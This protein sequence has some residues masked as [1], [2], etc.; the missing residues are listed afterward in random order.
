MTAGSGRIPSLDGLRAV[1]ISLVLY[2]HLEGGHGF[3]SLHLTRWFGDVA[4]LGVTVFFVI[5]GFLIT[6]LLMSERERTSTISLKNFYLRRTLRIFPAFYAFILALVLADAIG[7]ID[8]SGRDL[9][10]AVTYTVNYDVD[11]SWNIGHL[12]SLSIE[13]QFYLL[14]PCVFLMLRERRALIA[15]VLAFAAGPLVRLAMR[16]AFPA[17][18]PWRDLEIFPAMADSI[19]IGCVLALLRPW[20]LEQAWYLRLSGSA[21]LALVLVPL[22]LVINSRLGYSLVDLVGSPILLVSVAL[23]IEASTRRAESIAGRFLNFP[24]VVFLGVLSYSL[25]LWQQPFL[26]RHLDTAPTTFPLNLALAFGCALLS[27]FLI[28]RPLVGVR[29]RLERS[30]V[31]PPSASEAATR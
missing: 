4:H 6:S 26:N 22:I 28:E 13:E 12:W 16:L 17:G 1:S 10:F 7:W 21:W 11:R 9:A 24:P 19:A 23:L 8:L 14:W 27:Y 5:S 2:G 30:P 3:A 20:L 18:S 29:R 25:Y 31:L 15:A